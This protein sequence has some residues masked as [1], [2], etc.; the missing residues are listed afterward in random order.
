MIKESPI[1]PISNLSLFN[2]ISTQISR[3]HQF[4]A[5]V[6]RFLITVLLPASFKTTTEK[7]VMTN[8]MPIGQGT[9]S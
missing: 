8:C 1:C 4:L 5:M 6:S 2:L 9:N 3:W 7:L